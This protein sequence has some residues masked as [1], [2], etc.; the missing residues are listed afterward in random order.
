MGNIT[1]NYNNSNV[2]V[3][4]QGAD[5]N[6]VADIVIQKLETRRNRSIGGL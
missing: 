6:Q 5:A 4:A 1:N 3:M 2:N